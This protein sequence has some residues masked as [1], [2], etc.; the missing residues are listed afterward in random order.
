M[1]LEAGKVAVVTGAASGIGLALAERFARDGLNVVLGDVDQEALASAVDRIGAL[2]V[3]A[4]PVG[5]CDPMGRLPAPVGQV[6]ACGQSA[7]RC[8]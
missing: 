4:L 8:V 5:S 3:Q 2:G 7:A 6:E 1:K